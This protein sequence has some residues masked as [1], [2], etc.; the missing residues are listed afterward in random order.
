MHQQVFNQHCHS[1]SFTY[2]QDFLDE[3]LWLVLQAGLRLRRRQPIFP[4]GRA[5]V[6]LNCKLAN[7][8]VLYV[9]LPVDSL[10]CLRGLCSEGRDPGA[11]QNM[12]DEASSDL[13][14]SPSRSWQTPLCTKM[15]EFDCPV[16]TAALSLISRL[17]MEWLGKA[18][19]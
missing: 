13:S 5:D 4:R 10:W 7:E 9:R 11:K 14:V 17:E 19:G 12:L 18:P 8:V 6:I 3:Q 2:L 1:E 16:V 15:F